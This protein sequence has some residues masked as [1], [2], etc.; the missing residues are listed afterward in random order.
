[1][2]IELKWKNERPTEAGLY[3][4]R[5]NSGEDQG[6]ATLVVMQ[7]TIEADGDS[8]LIC[9][10]AANSIERNWSIRCGGAFDDLDECEPDTEFFGPISPPSCEN[11]RTTKYDP[12]MS[13]G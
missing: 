6:V 5:F 12:K 8:W 2:E 10:Y 11:Y 1:M 13:T 4:V 9:K 3:W 7:K